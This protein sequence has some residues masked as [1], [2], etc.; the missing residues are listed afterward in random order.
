MSAR[1][2]VNVPDPGPGVWTLDMAF[3][4]TNVCSEALIFGSPTTQGRPMAGYGGLF[5]RGPRSF[6]DRGDISG[7]GRSGGTGCHGATGVLA[8]LHRQ[9]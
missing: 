2:D 8:G 4:L 9:T 7:L 6:L 3:E 5:W 1:I